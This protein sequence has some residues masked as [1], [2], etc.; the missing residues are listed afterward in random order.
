M[1]YSFSDVKCASINAG[2]MWKLK[3]SFSF[4]YQA[5]FDG[6]WGSE[7]MNKNLNR[8]IEKKSDTL[9]FCTIF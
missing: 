8:E 6:K 5:E 9:N 2:I 7:F 1:N 4:N 3:E